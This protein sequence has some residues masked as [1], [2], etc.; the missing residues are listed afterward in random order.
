MITQ[1]SPLPEVES[2]PPLQPPKVPVGL[3]VSVRVAPLE[4]VATHDPA[5]LAQLRPAGVLVTVP[6]PEPPKV[7]VMVGPDAPP[8]PLPDELK[9]TT[10]PVM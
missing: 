2:Q 3:A 10:L 9:Q 1:L 8:P 7:S 5:E 6:V 4:N